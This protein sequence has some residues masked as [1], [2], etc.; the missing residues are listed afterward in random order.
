MEVKI[1]QQ[2]KIRILDSFT[3]IKYVLTDI[4]YIEIL[5]N[6]IILERKR[7]AFSF[8][9]FYKIE[10]LNNLLFFFSLLF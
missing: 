9:G 7:L 3:G 2:K 1:C 6:Q 8:A 10:V 4:T 5:P